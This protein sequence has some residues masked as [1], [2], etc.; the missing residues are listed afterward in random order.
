VYFGQIG[1]RI[2]LLSGGSKRGQEKD[3]RRALQM[4]RN[5]D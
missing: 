1:D 2:H 5:H 3:I 4:W